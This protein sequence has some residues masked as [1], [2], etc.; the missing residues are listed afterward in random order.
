MKTKFI[1]QGGF[2]SGQTNENN[3]D[4]YKETLKNTLCQIYLS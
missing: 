2:S 1:L 4:F 3:T